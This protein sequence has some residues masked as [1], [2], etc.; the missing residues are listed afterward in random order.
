MKKARKTI[1]RAK[2]A[3]DTMN[4][5]IFR[6]RPY[7]QETIDAL[8]DDRLYFSTP[9]YFN[10]PYDS[11]MYI[12][13][14]NLHEYINMCLEEMP[15]YIKRLKQN[16][17]LKGNFAE[18][19]WSDC[20]PQKEE[21]HKMFIERVDE[22]IEEIKVKINSNIKEI[23]FSSEHLSIL[24]WAHYADSHKGFAIVYSKEKFTEVNSYNKDDVKLDYKFSFEEVAYLENRVDATR[25]VNDY[26][27]KYGM[28]MES[29]IINRELLP[30]PSRKTLKEIITTKD[31]CWAYEKEYRLIPRKLDFINENDL[32]YINI[33]PDAL[34]AGVKMP[35]EQKEEL[36]KIAKEKKIEMYEAWINDNDSDFKVVFQKYGV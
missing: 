4:T 2:K 28:P 7:N 17:P 36:F 1:R 6:Y 18:A 15:Q 3:V 31:K 30:E 5:S 23:C 11:L 24:M 16:N 33:K 25:F 20:N 29:E 8:K 34:I 26:L 27:L 9:K 10:D 22:V 21:Q 32:S 35:E 13:K 14:K 12:N 19:F